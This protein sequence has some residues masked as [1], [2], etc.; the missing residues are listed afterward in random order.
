[1]P[2][3]VVALKDEISRLA[4]KEIK[5]QTTALRKTSTQH[6]K[7]V[8]EMKRRISDLEHKVAILKKQVGREIPSQVNEA[9]AEGVRFSAR[10]LRSHRKRLGLSA[11]AY[12]KII[13]VTGKAV[14][15]WENEETHPRKQQL[16]ALAALRRMG[17]R[18]AQARIEELA[19]KGSKRR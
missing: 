19:K 7:A 8:A 2:N 11:A 17:K 10:G 6:R 4:R 9:D 15:L 3:I 1:M 16:A 12:G 18:E 13:G 5:S 14:Y